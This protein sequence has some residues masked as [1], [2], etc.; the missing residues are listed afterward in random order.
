MVFHCA[1]G[2]YGAFT[3]FTT[4]VHS[5]FVD[6]PT[7]FCWPEFVTRIPR[8]TFHLTIRI[9]TVFVMAVVLVFTFVYLHLW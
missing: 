3:R 5:P 6:A 9:L 8:T 7:S 2:S 1:A 4:D